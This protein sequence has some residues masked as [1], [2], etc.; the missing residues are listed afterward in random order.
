MKIKD[1]IF[2]I[3]AI[4][5]SLL[6]GIPYSVIALV[7]LMS[8]DYISGLV[9]AAVFKASPKTA[10][11]GLESRAGWKGLVRKCL[12]LLLVIVAYILDK[13]IGTDFVVNAVAVGFCLNE[14]LSLIEN[15]GLAGVRLPMALINAIEVLKKQVGE[16]ADPDPFEQLE[17]RQE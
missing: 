17:K 5:S 10:G 7:I 8:M 13:L 15:A 3:V 6:G 12:T 14:I 4:V 2:G 16:Q 1:I 9:V 11:G